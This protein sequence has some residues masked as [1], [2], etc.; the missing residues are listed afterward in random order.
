MEVVMTRVLD[1]DDGFVSST[2]PTIQG[3]TPIVS[4]STGSPSLIDPA[5]GI[6]IQDTA[7]E[8]IF[9]AGDGGPAD[10]TANPQIQAASN[11]GARLMLIGTSDTDT[12]TIEDGDGLALNGSMLIKNMS[13]IELT[14]NGSVWQEISRND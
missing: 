3:I 10:I 8:I 9:I 2:A 14:F 6:L 5:N 4:G 13:V 12:V 1:I 11:V 7:S